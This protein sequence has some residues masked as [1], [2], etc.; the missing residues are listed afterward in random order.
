ME[1]R[2]RFMCGFLGGFVFSGTTFQKRG[3]R[4]RKGR[5]EGPEFPGGTPG[6]L[7]FQADPGSD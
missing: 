2:I 1:R 4:E 5:E 6:L 3:N 7:S